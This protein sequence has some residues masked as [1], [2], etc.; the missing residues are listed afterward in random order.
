MM[1]VIQETENGSWLIWCSGCEIFH[2]FD[3]KW[4][5]NG[6]TE[7]P[8]FSPSLLVRYD[9][10]EQREQRRCHSFVRDGVWE[11]L[12]DCTHKLAGQKIPVEKMPND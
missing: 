7:K 2:E 8:T 10:G 5:F 4:E 3:T 12:S 11:Y 1:K 9:Y 6:N